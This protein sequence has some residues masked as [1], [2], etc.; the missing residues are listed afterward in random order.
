MIGRNEECFECGSVE[1]L[2]NHHVVPRSLGGTKTIPL[3]CYCHGKVHGID[4]SNH[5][6]LIKEGIRKTTKELGRPNYGKFEGETELLEL[7]RGIRD[8]ENMSYFNIAQK[9]NQ[10]G[11]P[12]RTGKPWHGEVVRRLCGAERKRKERKVE[13]LSDHQDIVDL[14]NQK[15]SIRKTAKLTGKGFS[16]VQRVKKLMAE[17]N[18]GV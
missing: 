13:K 12:T 4:F 3:C 2:H 5:S 7:I 10:D 6:N 1:N 11:I 18:L 14:L 17:M 8:K 15:V 9:L 16:T